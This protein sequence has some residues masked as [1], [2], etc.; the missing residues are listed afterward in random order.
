MV[1][2]MVGPTRLI[3]SRGIKL[4]STLGGSSTGSSIISGSSQITG[5]TSISASGRGSSKGSG[6]SSSIGSS[7]FSF[8]PFPFFDGFVLTASR[9]S[10]P[11]I[12]IS[13]RCFIRFF[14]FNF[15]SFIRLNIFNNFLCF[16]LLCQFGRLFLLCFNR[17]FLPIAFSCA[18]G[19]SF[20][21]FGYLCSGCISA[22]VFAF[23]FWDFLFRNFFRFFLLLLFWN[24]FYRFGNFFWSIKKFCIV[25]ECC[26]LDVQRFIQFFFDYPLRVDR[27]SSIVMVSCWAKFNPIF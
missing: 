17:R 7:T 15:G 23:R 1:P 16:F 27:L 6:R 19:L 18:H 21:L 9:S 12:L 24:F 13:G 5:G 22:V 2:R 20:W 10:F 4:S 8:L 25:F 3:F 26:I 11:T 14:N